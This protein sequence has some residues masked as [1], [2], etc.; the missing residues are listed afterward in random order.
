MNNAERLV[1]SAQER[2]DG[3]PVLGHFVWFE[4][5][6]VHAPE[7]DARDAWLDAGFDADHAPKAL[8]ASGA[9]SRA[10]SRATVHMQ[11]ER[12]TQVDEA[13]DDEAKTIHVIVER[14]QDLTSGAPKLRY[15]QRSRVGYIKAKEEVRL[16]DPTDPV[17]QN[18]LAL[19][20]DYRLNVGPNEVRPG[21]TKELHKLGSIPL[22]Q[23]GGVY[24]VPFVEGTTD[25]PLKAMTQ[26][27]KKWGASRFYPVPQYD[28]QE[29]RDS[30]AASAQDSFSAELDGVR[31]ELETYRERIEDKDTSNPREGTIH[32]RLDALQ[33]MERRAALYAQAL[34]IKKEDLLDGIEDV[35]KGINELLADVFSV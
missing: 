4:L 10:I 22:R 26:L 16:E 34:D 8:K 9:Y 13:L 19:Y 6:S 35:R 24:F 23:N 27:V 30:V 3:L 7:M 12:D 2:G 33:D 18:I 11:D 29:L 1:K 21:I 15:V 17:A 25:E 5:S 31:K 20:D 28:T 32:K 14:Q